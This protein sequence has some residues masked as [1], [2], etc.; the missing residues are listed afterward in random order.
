MTQDEIAAMDGGKYI[1][2]LRGVRPFFSDK[3]DIT[4]HPKY[5]YLSDADPKNTFDMEKHLRCHPAVVKP[6]EVREGRKPGT[7]TF[8]GFT[9][10]GFNDMLKVH[11]LAQPRIYVSMYAR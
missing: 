6:D 10:D 11:P 5:R 3:F 8:L 7:F 2:Q 9:R 1:L 4:K